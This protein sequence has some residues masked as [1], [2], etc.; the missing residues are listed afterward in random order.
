MANFGSGPEMQQL[1]IVPAR[2]HAQRRVEV[3]EVEADALGGEGDFVRRAVDAGV[4]RAFEQDVGVREGH[5]LLHQLQ[6]LD[7]GLAGEVEQAFR[8]VDVGAH[9]VRDRRQRAPAMRIERAPHG[10][11]FVSTIV[12]AP[13][14]KSSQVAGAAS[15]KPGLA[16]D[17]RVPARADH[18]EQERPAIELAVDGAFLAD[19]GN[20]VVDHVLRDV[21]VPRLDDV[22]LDER[23]HFDERRLPDIDVPGAFLVLGL[24]DE[25][26]DAEALD[27]RDLIVDPGELRVHGRDAGMK[28]L[29]PLIEGRRQRAVRRK[30][31]LR[32]R[33]SPPL[34]R[35][36]GRGRRP[37]CA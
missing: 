30:R 14:R 35:R 19:R 10:A 5:D 8:R 23:R 31:R 18:V 11:A 28:V 33:T 22:G 20:D 24:G 7:G 27:R 26:L 21:V 17:A 9:A 34:R 36:R 4:R 2:G 32:R 16:G 29:D 12:L 25:A 15:A 13:A 37:G 6:R 1:R 3:F